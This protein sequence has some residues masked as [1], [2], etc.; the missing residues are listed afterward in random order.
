MGLGT[1]LH[2]PPPHLPNPPLQCFYNAGDDQS[3]FEYGNDEADEAQ[4]S[5]LHDV[6]EVQTRGPWARFRWVGGSVGGLAD[7]WVGG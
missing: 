2:H 1:P 3:F 4:G 5:T 6:S 7:E